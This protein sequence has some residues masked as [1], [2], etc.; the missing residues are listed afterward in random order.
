MSSRRDKTDVALCPA[1]DWTY[2]AGRP[3]PSVAAVSIRC[4]S[5]GQRVFNIDGRRLQ[6][7]S[8]RPGIASRPEGFIVRVC[9]TAPDLPGGRCKLYGSTVEFVYFEIPI[10]ERHLS[11]VQAN[12]CLAW[13]YRSGWL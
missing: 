2:S 8:T 7:S 1:G 3:G 9:A 4:R 6:I 5:V 11:G 12:A 13:G 10:G